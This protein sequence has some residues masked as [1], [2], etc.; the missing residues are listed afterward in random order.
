MELSSSEREGATWQ[1]ESKRGGRLRF[2]ETITEFRDVATGEL[3]VT[4]TMVGVFT[5]RPV[6]Q[7]A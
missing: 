7:E 4:A 3:V 6:E 5:E 1:K 2:T